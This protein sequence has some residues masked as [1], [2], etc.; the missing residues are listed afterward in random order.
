MRK[1]CAQHFDRAFGLL[2]KAD[3]LDAKMLASHGRLDGLEATATLAPALVELQDLVLLRRRY[4]DECASLAH[5]ERQFES[6][7]ALRLL[8]QALARRVKPSRA[9]SRSSTDR[10]A[11]I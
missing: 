8:R 6:K 7:A 2:V 4:V 11:A 3:H 10:Q 9:A 5:L 1:G